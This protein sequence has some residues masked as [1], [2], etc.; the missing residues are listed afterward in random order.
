MHNEAGVAVWPPDS[1]PTLVDLE[2]QIATLET[3]RSQIKARESHEG[4]SRQYELV[5]YQLFNQTRTRLASR[6]PELLVD[7]QPSVQ[8]IFYDFDDQGESRIAAIE[9]S[10]TAG[11]D[12]RQTRRYQ[13]IAALGQRLSELRQPREANPNQETERNILTSLW[14]KHQTDGSTEESRFHWTRLELERLH[15]LTRHQADS[16]ESIDGFTHRMIGIGQNEYR[17]IVAHKRA[18]S[19][20]IHRDYYTQITEATA[21]DKDRLD[22]YQSFQSQL[23]A[24]SQLETINGTLPGYENLWEALSWVS[25]LHQT[26]NHNPTDIEALTRNYYS[27]SLVSLQADA[28]LA[29]QD[30]LAKLEQIH[31]ASG[32]IPNPVQTLGERVVR[33][34]SS[35]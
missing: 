6:R 25:R 15:L 27:R 24:E 12:H 30:N 20:T 2:Q 21:S 7:L 10:L 23:R 13:I 5:Y 33:L 16:P 35:I 14:Y 1:Q 22:A 3:Q 19:L 11:Y 31:G 18:Q 17:A 29:N 26:W 34:A 4:Q 9:Q 28:Q 8:N 32:W